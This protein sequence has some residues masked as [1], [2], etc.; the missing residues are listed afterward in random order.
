MK[1]QIFAILHELATSGLKRL[2]F[3]GLGEFF[4]LKDWRHVLRRLRD[5]YEHIKVSVVTNFSLD[6]FND[7]DLEL[8]L[9]LNEIKISCDTL[10]PLLFHEIRVGGNLENLKSNIQRVVALKRDRDSE[11]PIL[12]FNITESD[13][14][15]S[16]LVELGRYAADCTINMSLSNLFVS[17]E[18]VLAKTGCLKKISEL[19][20]VPLLRAWEAINSLPRRLKAGNR[21]CEFDQVGPLFETLQDLVP[22]AKARLFMPDEGEKLYELWLESNSSVRLQ[23]FFFS[24]D[25]ELRGVLLPIEET[26]DLKHEYLAEHE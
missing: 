10:D 18:T 22:D 26:L 25:D 21:K 1:K 24:Y 9:S 14:I 15:V 4:I 8:L 6:K 7:S 13:K 20:G 11:Y 16:S 2:H 23:N 3:V 19:E 12:T 5:E 17:E